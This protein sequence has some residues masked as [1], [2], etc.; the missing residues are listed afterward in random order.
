MDETFKPRFCGVPQFVSNFEDFKEIE[1]G[2]LLSIMLQDS[3][4]NLTAFLERKSIKEDT[5]N[6]YLQ[7]KEIVSIGG[8]FI[9]EEIKVVEYNFPLEGQIS[10]ENLLNN[11]VKDYRVTD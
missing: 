6:I 5:Q 3:R 1:D 9:K 2:S 10:I 11:K 7:Y 4:V 8:L